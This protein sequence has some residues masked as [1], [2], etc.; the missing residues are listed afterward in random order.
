MIPIQVAGTEILTKCPRKLYFFV[1][2]EYGVKDE[3]IRILADYYG[4]VLSVDTVDAVYN[5]MSHKRLFPLKPTLYVCRYDEGFVSKVDQAYATKLLKC[6][7]VGTLICVYEQPKHATKLDKLFP[8]NTVSIDNITPEIQ[9]SYLAGRCPSVPE[10]IQRVVVSMSSSY[11]QAKLLCST[12][13]A[14]KC[15]SVFQLSDAE[16]RE[17]LGDVIQS[18]EKVIRKGIAS[19]NFKYIIKLVDEC[20]DL[21]NFLYAMLGTFVELDK[22]MYQPHANSDISEFAKRWNARDIYSMFCNTYSELLKSRSETTDL[23]S[24]I[25]YL[26]SLMQF[27]PIPNLE[28]SN[29]F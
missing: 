16:L 25:I 17:A 15:A 7:I 22:L 2:P 13:E 9:L 27:N 24:R 5:L 8:D 4:E 6:N 1:G 19:R 28:V 10:H 3:Y 18:N 11:G 29:E 20:D 21:N 12:L 14:A 23:K 26:I